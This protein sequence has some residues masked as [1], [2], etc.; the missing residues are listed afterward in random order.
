M[1]EQV[2]YFFPF[3]FISLYFIFQLYQISISN[4]PLNLIRQLIDQHKKVHQE[5]KGLYNHNHQPSNLAKQLTHTVEI[6]V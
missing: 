6:L 2:K 3:F 1:D 5:I 4:N